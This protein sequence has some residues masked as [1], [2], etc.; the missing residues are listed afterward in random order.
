MTA[1]RGGVFFG[2]R[3]SLRYLRCV[4]SVGRLL[5]RLRESSLLHSLSLRLLR[6]AY[7]RGPIGPGFE[8]RAYPTYVAGRRLAAF[9]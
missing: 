2:R 8:P 5:A 3:R 7:R 4:R 1:P 6:V 9:G